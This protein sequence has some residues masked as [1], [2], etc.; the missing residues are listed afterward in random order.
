MSR[1]STSGFHG[2]GIE[3]YS[4]GNI[5]DR[6]FSCRP[7]TATEPEGAADELLPCFSFEGPPTGASSDSRGL[8]SGTCGASSRPGPV[9]GTVTGWDAA[10]QA[11]GISSYE[12]PQLGPRLAPRTRQQRGM[13]AS[14]PAA[15]PPASKSSLLASPFA[16]PFTVP[17]PVPSGSPLW[18]Y[19]ESPSYPVATPVNTPSTSSRTPPRTAN[20]D[21]LYPSLSPTS[22]TSTGVERLGHLFQDHTR[23]EELMQASPSM[24]GAGR[25]YIP[26][27]PPATAPSLMRTAASSPSVMTAQGL[28]PNLSAQSPPPSLPYQRVGPRQVSA[29]HS[30]RRELGQLLVGKRLPVCASNAA[31]DRPV[32][33]QK[34]RQ[35]I[36]CEIEVPRVRT[37][38]RLH[39]SSKF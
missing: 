9:T 25:R 37:S 22:A 38:P 18:G 20:F 10:T 39:T 31:L 28:L 6:E 12:G 3:P 2:A 19:G 24:A 16:R 27:T 15:T 23:L 5:A 7:W 14:Q 26:R 36:G 33:L 1:P 4:I 21:L 8:I 17:A 32:I 30:D 34:L 35:A 11:H 29:A 13:K